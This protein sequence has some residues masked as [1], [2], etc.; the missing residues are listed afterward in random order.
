MAK[1]KAYKLGIPEAKVTVTK[2]VAKTY[3]YLTSRMNSGP[4]YKSSYSDWMIF[5]VYLVL[6]DSF[7]SQHLL[8]H[9]P[10]DC[11]MVAMCGKISIT[12]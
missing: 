5:D 3:P 11:T 10:I 9:K 4:V 7:L 2:M 12:A 8:Q 6:K 1:F